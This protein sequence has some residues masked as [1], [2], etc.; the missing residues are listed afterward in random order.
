[1]AAE[2]AKLA[3]AEEAGM[4][5]LATVAGTPSSAKKPKKKGKTDSRLKP[6][7][8]LGELEHD[9]LD[10]FYATELGPLLRRKENPTR[11]YMMQLVF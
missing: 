8:E 4:Q 1:M 3:A 11:R 2:A 6:R 5:Q 10:C 9:D 7:P